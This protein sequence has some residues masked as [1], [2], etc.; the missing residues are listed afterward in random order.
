MLSL[1]GMAP[2][3]RGRPPPP[4]HIRD[5]PAVPVCDPCLEKQFTILDPNLLALHLPRVLGA[6]TDSSCASMSD[7]M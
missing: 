4:R 7:S 2:L 6:D 3:T 5:A 1:R